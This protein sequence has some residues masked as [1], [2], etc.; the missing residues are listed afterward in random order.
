MTEKNGKN[1]LTIA[2][3]SH[4]VKMLC[5]RERPFYYE[6]SEENRKKESFPDWR[7]IRNM[8]ELV[9]LPMIQLVGLGTSS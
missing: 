4:R 9:F 8:L 6:N 5:E 7:I 1:G 2:M 3:R